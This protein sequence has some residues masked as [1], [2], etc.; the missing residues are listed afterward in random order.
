MDSIHQVDGTLMERNIAF[1]SFKG[2][3]GTISLGSKPAVESIRTQVRSPQGGIISVDFNIYNAMT[4]PY[5]RRANDNF[6]AKGGPRMPVNKSRGFSIL[7]L[8]IVFRSLRF[9]E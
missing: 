2:L 1:G 3:K 6:P 7:E 5:I 4:S 9:L 8:L